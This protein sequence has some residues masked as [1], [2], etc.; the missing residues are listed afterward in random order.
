MTS[1]ATL[2]SVEI[3]PRFNQKGIISPIALGVVAILVIGGIYLIN[4]KPKTSQNTTGSEKSTQNTPDPTSDWKTYQDDKYDF[5]VKYPKNWTIE[6]LS[7]DENNGSIRLTNA[8]KSVFVLIDTI[9]GPSLEKTGE[10]GQ[11][12][13]LLEGKLKT[14]THL[15]ILGFNRSNENDK[16]G[17]I[18]TGEETYN[19]KTVLFEERFVVSKNGKGLRM[20]SIYASDSKDTNEPITQEIMG[21]YKEQTQENTPIKGVPAPV[22]EFMDNKDIAKLETGGLS[23]NKGDSPP[24]VEGT[25]KADNFLATYVSLVQKGTTKVG[26]T[27][28]KGGFIISNQKNDGSISIDNAGSEGFES[29]S[30]SISGKDNC[31][32]IYNDENFNKSSCKYTLAFVV[33]GCKVDKG[34]ENFQIS[35]LMKSKKGE[36]CDDLAPV[37]YT[38]VA[39]EVD[40]L[41]EKIK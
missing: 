32:T 33:S 16:E 9:F 31:F 27:I 2:L 21:S 17:Y 30:T 19:D 14:N 36:G 13:D 6:N 38:I 40:G 39:K 8:E 24:N 11:V 34:L 29:G 1:Q 4:Q 15:K 3:M 10:M 5:T 23:V 35:S 22:S 28:S 12:V 18:A 37:G 20:H 7:S 26:D 41:L 25:Y